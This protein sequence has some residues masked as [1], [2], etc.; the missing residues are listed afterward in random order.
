MEWSRSTGGLDLEKGGE[1]EGSTKWVE[2]IETAKED[3]DRLRGPL[4]IYVQV[5]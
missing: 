3:I 4:L 1:T 5:S 2:A